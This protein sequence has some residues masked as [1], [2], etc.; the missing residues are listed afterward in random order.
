M[1]WCPLD[2]DVP[3]P[4]AATVTNTSAPGVSVTF[5][6]APALSITPK[7][8]PRTFLALASASRADLSLEAVPELFISFTTDG[9]LPL[10]PEPPAQVTVTLL[11]A[12]EPRITLLPVAQA[13]VTM[14]AAPDVFVSALGNDAKG[15]V[16]K[17]TWTSQDS[18]YPYDVVQYETG[19]YVSLTAN[20]NRPPTT[21]AE[22]WDLLAQ[23]TAGP[24]GDKGDTGSTGP[25]GPPGTSQI[26]W[27]ETPTGIID[28]VNKNYTSAYLYSP[29]QLAVFLNGMRQRRTD[30]YAETGAQSFSFVSAPLP[31]D[32]LSI[33][34][35]R[36]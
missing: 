12:A 36:S 34:Y 17:G 24:K 18:Y 2:I 32:S 5:G 4:A 30:D 13:A 26:I 31:G 19:S 35:V 16:W 29:N 7:A 22:D 10:I 23:G 20:S 25:P 28:G 6:A 14:E 1:P 9:L 8:P 27:G 11:A 3:S 33:D 15:F 21:S